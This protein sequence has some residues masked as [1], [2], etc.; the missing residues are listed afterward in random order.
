[1][2]KAGSILTEEIFRKSSANFSNSQ[3]GDGSNPATAAFQSTHIFMHAVH[4]ILSKVFYKFANT[5]LKLKN[6]TLYLCTHIAQTF[7]TNFIFEI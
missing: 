1:M 2:K 4:I 3:S 5:V 7:V 6:K